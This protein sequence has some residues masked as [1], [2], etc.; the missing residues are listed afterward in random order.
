MSRIRFCARFARR[1]QPVL[2]LVAAC[3]DHGQQ[4]VTAPEPP[5]VGSVARKP[6][7]ALEREREEFLVDTMAFTHLTREQVIDKTVVHNTGMKDEWAQWEKAGPMTDAR[8]KEF[9]KTTSNYIFDLGGWHLWDLEKRE[10][11]L[12]MVQQMKF[13]GAKN[14]LDFGGGVGFNAIQIAQAGFDVT[15]ADL[16]SVTLKFGAYRAEKHGVKLKLWKSDVEAMPP[17]KKYDVILCLDVLEHLPPDELRSVV[18]K[19]IQLK[20]AKT[21][22]VIHAPFGRTA[23]HPMHLDASRETI[24]QVQRLRTELPKE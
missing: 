13:I 20:H 19:L 3:H 24:E 21:A 5:G 6:D 2:V 16:D 17:D 1:V 4:P 23:Q 9:Y 15:L 8:I 18:D 7:P 10:S 14:I 22:V 11:D 12:A